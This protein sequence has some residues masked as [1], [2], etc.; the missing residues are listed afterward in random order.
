V[1]IIAATKKMVSESN[2]VLHKELRKNDKYI[3]AVP[4]FR[5]NDSVI[6]KKNNKQ[7]GLVNGSTGKIV[8]GGNSDDIDLVVDFDIEGKTALK[9]DQVKN[10]FR[11]DYIL[12]H[13]YGLTCHAAQ[14]SEFDV[15]IIILQPSEYLERS[16]LYTAITRAKKRVVILTK[17]DLIQR[18]IDRGFAFE[19]I[20]A[21]LYL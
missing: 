17:T 20:N 13:A 16:W 21:G 10:T 7:L 4:E 18:I 19:E 15:V 14:G 3:K 5:L 8:S 12:Q 11:G 2:Q 9:L 6:Y 1:H